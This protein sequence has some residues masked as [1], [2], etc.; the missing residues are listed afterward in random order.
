MAKANLM[1][2]TSEN[3]EAQEEVVA[4]VKEEQKD[5]QEEQ[6]ASPVPRKRL[7]RQNQKKE[8]PAVESP[9]EEV[10]EEK[11]EEPVK[12]AS[13]EVKEE[14]KEEKSSLAAADVQPVVEP[15][16]EE[17]EPVLG[18]SASEVMKKET[19]AYAKKEEKASATEE[20]KWFV[21]VGDNMDERKMETVTNRLERAQVDYIINAIGGVY[22]GPYDNNVKAIAGRKKIIQKGLKGS[23]ITAKVSDLGG[24]VK[25][26]DNPND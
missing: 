5:A 22:V 17:D 1:A 19:E 7:S 14:V 26:V 9:V 15:K 16:K 3:P 20:E 21:F 13:S 8:E 11:K 2:S 25:A 18:Q 24:I 23:I 4:E 12:E 6:A 10:K